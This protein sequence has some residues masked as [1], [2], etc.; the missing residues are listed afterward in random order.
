VFPTVL[1]LGF[2]DARDAA[3]VEL[4]VEPEPVRGRRC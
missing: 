1:P 2:D 3:E 4:A